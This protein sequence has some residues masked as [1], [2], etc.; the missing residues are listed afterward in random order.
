MTNTITRN[1]ILDSIDQIKG[2]T[3]ESSLD[4]LFS[5]AE[6]FDK[7]AMIMESYSGDIDDL[8]MFAVF[9]EADETETKP[10]ETT[11]TDSSTSNNSAVQQGDPDSAANAESKKKENSF[12]Y[13]VAHFIPNILKSIWEFIKKSWNGV[14]VPTVE[15]VTEATSSVIDKVLGKDESWVKAHAKELG[16]AGASLAAVLALV[17][18]L[19]KNNKT[20]SLFREWWDSIRNFF[21]LATAGAAMVVFDILSKLGVYSFKTN[22][23]FGSLVELLKKVPEFFKKLLK[24]KEKK[25]ASPQDITNELNSIVE[26]SEEIRKTSVVTEEAEEIP[27]DQLISRMTELDNAI[28]EVE[29]LETSVSLSDEDI[30]AVISGGNNADENQKKGIAALIQK[31]N[32]ATSVIGKF[33]TGTAKWFRDIFSSIK[34]LFDKTKELNNAMGNNSN[35]DSTPADGYETVSGDTAPEWVD[36]KFYSKG[37]DGTYTV[38]SAKPDD[39]DTSYTNYFTK[40]GEPKTETKEATTTA[41]DADPGPGKH[42]NGVSGI[43]RIER[44][45]KYSIEEVEKILDKY[46]HPD[47]KINPETHELT[48]NLF[49]DVRTTKNLDISDDGRYVFKWSDA[50]NAFVLGGTDEDSEDENVS[51]YVSNWYSR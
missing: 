44:G 31:V 11:S 23:K 43:P 33:I 16:L 17:A 26:Y 4:V 29:A 50:D 38:V 30:S 27:Q 37:E 3:M 42:E 22:V 2:I 51:E 10:A 48:Y 39:W 19:N 35:E 14:V 21:L 15:N 28:K 32:S 34:E 20:Q 18:F 40:S 7:S 47:A 36:G 1:E 41:T 8:D 46:G 24:I 25:N 6:T 9:Q 49:G 13:K 45:W 5:M 12:W